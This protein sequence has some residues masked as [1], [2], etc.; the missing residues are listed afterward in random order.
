MLKCYVRREQHESL[1]CKEFKEAVVHFDDVIILCALKEGIENRL[2]V[3]KS[4]LS[5]ETEESVEFV[6]NEI[7]VLEDYLRA[8]DNEID[9]KDFKLK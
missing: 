1:N 6:K 9:F 7:K 2:R 3:S 5:F 8:I 4:S